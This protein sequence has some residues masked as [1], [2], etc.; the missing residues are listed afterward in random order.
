MNA[1]GEREEV[2]DF[3]GSEATGRKGM[4]LILGGVAGIAFAI[5]GFLLVVFLLRRPGQMTLHALTTFPMILSVA[6]LSAGWVMI[7]TPRRVMI[8]PDGLTIETKRGTRDYRWEEVGC[9][10][11][12]TAGTSHRRRMNLTDVRGRS[13]LSVDE[14]FD[15]FD[16][17]S[18]TISRYIDAKG[19]DTAMRL[20][21]RK[22]HVR[23]FFCI[24]VGL[25]MGAG[26]VFMVFETQ[27]GVRASRLLREKGQ[28]GEG[29]IVRLFVAPNGFTKRLEYRVGSSATRNVEVDTVYWASLQG[30]K[31]VPVRY[32][33]DEP[34]I[35]KLLM[36]EVN[37]NEFLKTA[38]GGYGFAALG[39]LFSL[40]MTVGGGFMWFGWDLTHETKSQRW[41][42]KR[43][44]R[45]V[46][47]SKSK[48]GSIEVLPSDAWREEEPG[49]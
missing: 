18:T 33:P 28:L 25:L 12:G 21:R 30:A 32:V 4:G 15:R 23:A 3:A 42:L 24:L 44:G 20:L 7:R 35:N 16:A 1:S 6:A 5:V 8:R 27:N 39:A 43:Y 10:E 26:S 14:S 9:A 47:D 19:D 40:L 34:N 38:P 37:E 17:L 48:G 11:V 36:G 22:A 31:S 46:W 2:F 45:I 49:T 41:L 29:T 13:I